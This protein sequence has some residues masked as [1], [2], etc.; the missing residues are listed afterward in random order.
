MSLWQK[1]LISIGIQDISA[2]ASVI[3]SGSNF[4]PNFKAAAQ[5]AIQANQAL[6]MAAQTPNQ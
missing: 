3:V 1:I 2:V 5:A 6:A 4:G